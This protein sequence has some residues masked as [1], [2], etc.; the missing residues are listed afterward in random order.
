MSQ[1]SKIVVSYRD[2]SRSR[3]GQQ[4]AMPRNTCGKSLISQSSRVAQGDGAHP[5]GSGSADR[6]AGKIRAIFR[7]TAPKRGTAGLR[8]TVLFLC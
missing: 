2:A 6:Q 3:P 1:D 7:F 5:F 8:P 4:Q